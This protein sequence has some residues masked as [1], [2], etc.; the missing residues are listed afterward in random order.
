MSGSRWLTSRK[1]GRADLRKAVYAGLGAAFVGSIGLAILLSRTNWNEDIFEGW[2]ML[3][4]AFFV[5]TMILFMM[6]TGRKA[7][8]AKS[9]AR[10]ESWW[11]RKLVRTVPVRLSDGSAGGSGNR[12]DAGGGF[13][14]FDRA[15]QL[16]WAHSRA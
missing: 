15:A 13:A 14:E 3:A 11:G 16:F 2:I 6:R 9:K 8:R 12:A 10:S 5:L 1:I 4:A 7:Q